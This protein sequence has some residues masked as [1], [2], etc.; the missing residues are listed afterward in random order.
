MGDLAADNDTLNTDEAHFGAP[1]TPND[2]EKTLWVIPCH[3]RA[4]EALTCASSQWQLDN[5]GIEIALDYA[6]ADVAW[7]YADIALTPSDFT[8]VQ[9]LERMILGLIR[10]PDEQQSKFSVTLKV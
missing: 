4:I 7:R 8:K 10:R 6:R 9:A 2:S 1:V 5:K 3:W